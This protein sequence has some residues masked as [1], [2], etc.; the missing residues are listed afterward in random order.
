MDE[1]E[2]SNSEVEELLAVHT[3]RGREAKRPRKY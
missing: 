1:E 2:S 3:H